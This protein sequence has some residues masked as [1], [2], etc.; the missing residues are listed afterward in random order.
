[1]GN[2]STIVAGKARRMEKTVP[3]HRWFAREVEERVEALE[4]VS[5]RSL[6]E[7]RYGAHAYPLLCIESRAG[8]RP[9]KGQDRVLI[10][11][12]VHGDEPAGVH[13]AL[14]FLRDVMPAYGDDFQFVV[15]PCVN[16]SGYEANT[17]ETI[18]GVNLNRSFRSG[19]TAAEVRAIE[20]WLAQ[21]RPSFRVTFDLHEIPPHYRDEGFVES[22]NPDATYLYETVSDQSPRLG[23]EMIA[24]LSDDVDVCRWPTIYHD[25]NDGGVIAYPEACRNRVYAERTTLDA[26]LNGL[27][28]HHSF[29]TETPTTWDFPRRVTTHLTYVRTALNLI[30]AARKNG[31]RSS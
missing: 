24:A 15:L 22:D 6:G 13:A 28:T 29:T 7:V 20:A 4:G 18:S 23:H 14:D 10:S 27:F 3:I 25:V 19:T 31:P 11:A 30:R 1:M 17:L 26:Y 16:P 2:N 12:G 5:V 21:A 8:A 9:A